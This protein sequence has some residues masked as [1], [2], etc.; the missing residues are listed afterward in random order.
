MSILNSSVNPSN[1][2]TFKPLPLVTNGVRAAWG[3]SFEVGRHTYTMKVE[4]VELAEYGLEYFYDELVISTPVSGSGLL[5]KFDNIENELG[6]NTAYQRLP[7]DMQLS[8]RELLHLE[9][10][11]VGGAMEFMKSYDAPMLIGVPNDTKLERWYKRLAARV[12]QVGFHVEM[13]ATSF[14]RHK[15]ALI[16]R[17]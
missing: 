3:T 1:P 4:E 11:L 12:S 9:R 7:S 5:I 6:E 13:R 17:R 16:C 2:G 8:I 10:F 15:V 14:H